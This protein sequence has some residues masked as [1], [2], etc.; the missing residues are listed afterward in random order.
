MTEELTYL[1]KQ[2]ENFKDK[3][4]FI[5][6]EKNLLNLISSHNHKVD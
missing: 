4:D 1:F 2:I 3:I 6:I 5:Q